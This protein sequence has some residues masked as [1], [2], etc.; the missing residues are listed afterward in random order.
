MFSNFAKM[1]KKKNSSHII[2]THEI[3]IHVQRASK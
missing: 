1:E 3:G 2:I